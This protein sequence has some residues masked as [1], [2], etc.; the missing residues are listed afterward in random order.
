MEG[1]KDTPAAFPSLGCEHANSN[2]L[3]ELQGKWCPQDTSLEKVLWTVS[4]R[5][6]VGAQWGSRARER[7]NSIM[8]LMGVRKTKGPGAHTLTIGSGPRHGRLA[9]LVFLRVV[10]GSRLI[11]RGLGQ[12]CHSSLGVPKG[13]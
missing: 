9:S 5:Q 13:S 10:V 2:L 7:K 1:R 11:A 3:R 4:T 12:G 8:Q 6:G